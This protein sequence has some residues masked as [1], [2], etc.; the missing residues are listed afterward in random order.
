M[1]VMLNRPAWS[2]AGQKHERDRQMK[3]KHIAVGVVLVTSWVVACLAQ[4]SVPGGYVKASVASKEVVAAATFAVKAEAKALPGTKGA[5]SPKVKLVKILGAEEQ[6][7]SGK[8]F[9]LK[10]KVELN[11]ER[12]LAQATVWWQAWRKPDGYRL[13]SWNWE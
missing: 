11:G 10:L 5:P 2:L 8:N 13:T 12:K 9:R 3:S 6:V 1:G 4:E 7:V